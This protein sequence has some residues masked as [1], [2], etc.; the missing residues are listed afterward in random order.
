MMAYKKDKPSLAKYGACYYEIGAANLTELE[1]SQI[2]I[3]G[4]DDV[5]I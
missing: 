1:K 5:E 4:K 2:L 3:D